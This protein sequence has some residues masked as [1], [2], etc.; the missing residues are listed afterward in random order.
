MKRLLALDFSD[1][2]KSIWISELNK[3]Y[4][5]SGDYS[6]YSF[7]PVILLDENVSFDG[8]IPIEK[9]IIF[10]VPVFSD[11][12][13]YLAPELHYKGIK[14]LFISEVRTALDYSW[15]RIEATPTRLLMIE[16][17]GIFTRTIASRC[18]SIGKVHK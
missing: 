5:A 8:Y 11:G 1:H 15:N 17:D 16:K 3:Y 10:S 13:S 2:Q 14:G 12:I 18:L 9:N 4:K 7:P 6:I